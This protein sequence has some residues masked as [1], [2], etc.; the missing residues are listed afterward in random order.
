M[1]EFV[2]DI[3]QRPV[4]QIRCCPRAAESHDLADFFVA[5]VIVVEEIDDLSLPSRQFGN[6]FSD[7]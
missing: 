6:R 4:E 5:E 1:S 3:F 2:F 7:F